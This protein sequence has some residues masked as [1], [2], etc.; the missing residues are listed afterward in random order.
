MILNTS[1]P[2]G[3]TKVITAT[4][5]A[6]FLVAGLVIAAPS[7]YAGRAYAQVNTPP[8]L[9]ATTFPP[10]IFY[11]LRNQPSYAVTIPFSSF[12]TPQFEPADVSIPTG[13]T[14]IWFNDDSAPHTVTTMFNSTYTPPHAL[15]SGPIQGNGGSF[16]Q[17]FTKAGTY[18]YY[19][20]FDPSV[21]GRITVSTGMETGKNFNMLIGGGGLPF[22]PSHAKR[23][24]LTFVP[25]T[26]K[27]PPTVALT[28]NVTL[29]NSTGKPIYSHNYDTA[30]GILDLELVPT[31]KSLSKNAT[32]DFTTWGPDFIGQESMRSTGTFHI[33]GPVLIDNS[34]YS[35]RAEIVANSNSILS[36][37]VVDTFAL[38][39]NSATN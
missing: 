9:S 30:D 17:T 38:P 4:T 15:N 12:G 19:D 16:I 29:L 22:D 13:M 23:F 28:Y 11:Q 39:P 1:V 26:V 31:H 6:L 8:S 7:L 36:K 14:V 37:P 10:P 24:V 21:H 32:S 3:R 20:Q 18:D 5:L 25:K 33:K 2:R 34:P 35:I 27:I